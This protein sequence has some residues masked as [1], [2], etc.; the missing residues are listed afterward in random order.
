[1]QIPATPATPCS[2]LP[3]AVCCC[4]LMHCTVECSR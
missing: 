1:V 2:P 3:S 4:R